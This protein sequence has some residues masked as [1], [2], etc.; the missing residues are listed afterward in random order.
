V[1]GYFH[2]RVI[3]SGPHT[4]MIFRELPPDRTIEEDDIVSLDL[5]AVFGELEADF[6]RTYVLGGDP[7]RVRLARDQAV[8]FRE[9]QTLYF[10]ELLE[11]PT[12]APAVGGWAALPAGE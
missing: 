1:K 5:G 9:C 6:G 7:E 12:S 8:I 3:R 11:G 4:R 2:R 10:E